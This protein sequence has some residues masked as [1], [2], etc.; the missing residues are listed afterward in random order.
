VEV[1]QPTAGHTAAELA[2]L[3]H[4]DDCGMPV[5]WVET[6]ASAQH[7][8]AQRPHCVSQAASTWSQVYHPPT[9]LCRSGA[10][11]YLMH[12]ATVDTDAL[13]VSVRRSVFAVLRM[14]TYVGPLLCCG[15]KLDL[16]Q[17]NET[18]KA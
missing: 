6:N 16:A 1:I 13:T 14:P 18:D 3:Q 5:R 17:Q 15:W 10:R 12:T 4:C 2:L 7:M 9:L 11:S 8:T